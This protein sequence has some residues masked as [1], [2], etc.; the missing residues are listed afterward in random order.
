MVAEAVAHAAFF[1]VGESQRGQNG[2]G[3][4]KRSRAMRERFVRPRAHEGDGLQTRGRMSKKESIGQSGAQ[5]KDS[6][7]LLP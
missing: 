1:R 4:K 6:S 3:S 2:N 7:E 5:V